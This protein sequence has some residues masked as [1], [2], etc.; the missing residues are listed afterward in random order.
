MLVPAPV[1]STCSMGGLSS[2]ESS[3]RSHVVPA[4]C[5]VRSGLRTR[6]TCGREQCPADFSVR[7]ALPLV[8]VSAQPADAR[9]IGTGPCGSVRTMSQAQPSEDLKHV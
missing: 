1:A 5:S 3:L 4:S 9:A 2:I 6:A 8:L 7:W